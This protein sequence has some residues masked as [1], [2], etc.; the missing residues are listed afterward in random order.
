LSL[1]LNDATGCKAPVH[2]RTQT[3]KRDHTAPKKGQPPRTE[4]SQSRNPNS[5]KAVMDKS[6]KSLWKREGNVACDIAVRKAMDGISRTIKF[7][8]MKNNYP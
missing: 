2:P 6:D 7:A 4:N 8:K 1:A 3:V 5:A